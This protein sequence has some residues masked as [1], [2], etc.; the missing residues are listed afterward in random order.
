MAQAREELI[1]SVCQKEVGVYQQIFSTTGLRPCHVTPNTDSCLSYKG[2]PPKA[3]APS[4]WYTRVKARCRHCTSLWV[5]H[6]SACP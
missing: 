4:E 5:L 6:V 3:S 2:T 1:E